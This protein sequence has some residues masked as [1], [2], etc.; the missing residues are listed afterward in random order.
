MVGYGSVRNVVCDICDKRFAHERFLKA[1][2]MSTHKEKNHHCHYCGKAFSE[3]VF[4]KRHEKI[5][6]NGK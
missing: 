2:V 5:H 6:I 3:L 4:L 1:H